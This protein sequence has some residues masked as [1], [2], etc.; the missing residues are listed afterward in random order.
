VKRAEVLRRV[1]E[2][3]TFTAY[4][5]SPFRN[6]DS[7]T[8]WANHLTWSSTD[9]KMAGW[10]TKSPRVGRSLTSIFHGWLLGGGSAAVS[11]N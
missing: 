8:R 2:R 10:I 11:S 5:D 3:V 1:G 6:G 7:T 9:M 4:E